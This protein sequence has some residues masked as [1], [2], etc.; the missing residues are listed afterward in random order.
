MAFT[1]LFSRLSAAE[2]DVKSPFQPDLL[3]H[4]NE[5]GNGKRGNAR[6]RKPQGEQMGCLEKRPCNQTQSARSYEAASFRDDDLKAKHYYMQNSQHTN[7]GKR[8]R[9]NHR[10]KAGHHNTSPNVHNNRTNNNHNWNM[11]H[12]QK[13]RTEWQNNQ[14]RQ[15]DGWRPAYRGGRH[16][17]RKGGRGKAKEKQ[18]SEVKRTRFMS[19]EFKEQNALCVD[20]RLLCKHF[21]LGKCIKDGDCQLE[22]IQGYNDLF[23]EAC[24]F[25][26]QGACFKG[27]SCPYMHKSFPCKFFHRRGKCLQGEDCKFSH[28]P[29]SDL[30]KRLL[31]E[32]LKR[33]QE[34]YELAKKAERESL[35]QPVNTDESKNIDA[36]EPPDILSQPLRPNFYQHVETNAENESS[37]TQSEKEPTE[38]VKEEEKSHSSDV[39]QP[40]SSP[41]TYS[42]HKEPVSYSVEAV[43]GPQ[44]SKP[45]SR[46]FTSTRSQESAPQ[47]PSDSTPVSAYQSL[48]PYSV[49]AVL[50]SFKSVETP[51][52]PPAQTL[53]YTPKAN[54]AESAYSP[55]ISDIQN[56]KVWYSV[57]EG[58]KS[59]D[60]VFK[61]LPSLQT[62]TG[63]TSKALP[64]LIL[65][66]EDH[67]T[68]VLNMQ[69]SPK[70][71]HEVK[72]ESF[73]SQKFFFSNSKGDVKESVHLSTE[74]KPS[75]NCKSIFQVAPDKPRTV[76]PSASSLSSENQMKPNLFALTSDSGASFKPY[77][78]PTGFTK[79]SSRAA[80]HTKPVSISVK[81]SESADPA[82]HLAAKRP[83]ASDPA[84]CSSNGP[85]VGRL[86]GGC[87]PALRTSFHNLFASPITDSMKPKSDSVT[88]ST[89]PKGSIQSPGPDLKSACLKSN[90]L[91]TVVN[92]DKAPTL[93]FVSLFEAPLNDAPLPG[94][95]TPN[96]PKTSSASEKTVQT[97]DDLKEISRKP[98]FL[99]IS[100]KPKIENEGTSA[101]RKNLIMNPACGLV[102][103]SVSE[104]SSSPTPCITS[105][106]TTRADHQMPEM[107]LGKDVPA[108]S[109]LKTLFLHLSPY[110]QNEEQQDSVQI[111]NETKD[112]MNIEVLE[113]QQK[114]RK[115]KGR[116]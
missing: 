95:S 28:E 13:E 67:K 32:A 68:Q 112:K 41:S 85:Q 44:L 91:L 109:I 108:S 104:W 25:Y 51:N 98:K 56:K 106:T 50:K 46:F 110:H 7:A 57:N 37:S 40:P 107:S 26:I 29:L 61:S 4:R 94:V 96:Y 33:E 18:D 36:D 12:E 31:D 105:E 2:V 82:S 101:E 78:F 102:P 43:L 8:G 20:G 27:E 111:G 81:S 21:L 116:R 86:A 49:E 58:N 73:H 9:H 15:R 93:S 35:E 38:N 84:R 24:K 89:S 72:S 87:K 34:L 23:K 55:L 65:D 14:H 19:E 83:P 69:E 113:K 80:V 76:F 63:L 11:Q 75:V 45:F 79:F 52:P 115:A 100:S 114:K 62:H 42:D 5:T 39:A 90:P 54:L 74:N 92:P 47:P 60:K 77:G 10:G 30:T 70:P 97:V 48:I 1:N 17:S 22:H 59:Q 3:A 64:D 71:V 53:S 88:T 16:T 103:G 6:K 66:S 99:K